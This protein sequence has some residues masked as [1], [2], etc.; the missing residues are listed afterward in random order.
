MYQIAGGKYWDLEMVS[1]ADYKY[2]WL[3]HLK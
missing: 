3:T 2:S 1:G